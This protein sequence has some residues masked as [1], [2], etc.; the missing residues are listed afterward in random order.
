MNRVIRSSCTVISSDNEYIIELR[1]RDIS[2][3]AL[4]LS[5]L[6]MGLINKLVIVFDSGTNLHILLSA[7]LIPGE[8]A[9]INKKDDC[10][11]VKVSVNQLE[12]LCAFLLRTY[13]DQYSEVN[14]IHIEGV[15]N[16]KNYDL[17]LFFENVAPALTP[18]E[19]SKLM[20]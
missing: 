19:V 14:H 15:K 4:E 11:I 1:H 17:T 6:M 3:I 9:V 5:M 18:E 20:G 13:R 8:K 12:Y 10:L 7:N 16:G 2:T